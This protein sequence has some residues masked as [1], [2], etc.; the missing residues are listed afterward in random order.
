MREH[1]R[2]AVDEVV[3]RHPATRPVRHDV[4]KGVHV[5]SSLEKRIPKFLRA[6]HRVAKPTLA[7]VP[8]P[9]ASLNFKDE[10]PA[11]GVENH[12]VCFSLGERALAARRAQPWI[13]VKD[14]EVIPETVSQGPVDQFLGVV[15]KLGGV[16]LGDH[17]RHQAAPMG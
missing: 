16:D 4:E 1:H 8:D 11:G 13:G 5:P 14:V 3:S 17:T 15:L 2:V 7:I 12:E 9:V 10:H 6:P